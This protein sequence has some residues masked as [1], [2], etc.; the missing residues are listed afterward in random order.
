[1]EIKTETNK[2]EDNSQK[3][4]LEMREGSEVWRK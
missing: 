3:I 1:M 2:H 4:Y